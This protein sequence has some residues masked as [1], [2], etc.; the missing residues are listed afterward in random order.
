MFAAFTCDVGASSSKTDLGFFIFPMVKKSE[1]NKA[2]QRN[3]RD[4]PFSVLLM[5][6]LPCVADL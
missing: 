1:P 3:A 2:A 5:A 6:V 4:W